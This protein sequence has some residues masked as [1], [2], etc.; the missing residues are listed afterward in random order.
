MIGWLPHLDLGR[1][2]LAM[3]ISVALFGV[4]QNERNPPESGSFD[5]PLDILNTPPGLLIVGDPSATTAQVRVSAPRENWVTMRSATLR[6]SVDLSRGSTGVNDYP[7]LVDVPD[8]RV[9]VIEVLPARV[10]IRLDESLERAVP[11]RL[12]RSG[13]VPFGYSSGEAEID[14]TTVQVTG[15]SS[16]VSQVENVNVDLKLDG[17]TFD[18]DGR[19]TATPV[20]AQGLAINA[21]GRG[22]RLT[23]PAV[24]V[25]IPISQQL[26]Y[27]TV[28]IQPSVVG[29]VQNGYIIEGVSTEPSAIT[30]VGNP[31]AVGPVNFADTERVDVTDATAPITRQVSIS[32]PDGV[33][34]LQQDVVR[35]TVRVTPLVLTQS[36][37]AVPVPDGLGQGLQIISPLPSVQVVFQGPANALRSLGA[38]D[39]QATVSLDA[40]TA[41]SHRA[42]VDVDAPS[43][44]S[45]QSVNP[46][47]IGVTLGEAGLA[48]PAAAPQPG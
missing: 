44:V 28:G 39:F 42:T 23:P 7:V 47:V 27:K 31:R 29:A 17:V 22:L 26:S 48:S 6:A 40:L 38:G 3:L 25:H 43:G 14:P 20:D 4:V 21:E 45:V 1:G 33:S 30:V 8:P 46:R 35:V 37:T 32:V 11:V 13:A 41:G 2:F 34:V 15:P 10:T 24:R 5:V 18:V 19:Y 12:N 9:R 16:V 36:F